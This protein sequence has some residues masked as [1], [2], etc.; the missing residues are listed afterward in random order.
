MTDQPLKIWLDRNG[1][2]LRLRLSRPKANIVDAE[3]IGAL[4]AAI[5]DYAGNDDILAILIDHL[6]R[7]FQD[8]SPFLARGPGTMDG[9]LAAQA[10]AG[11]NRVGKIQL[12]VKPA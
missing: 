4:D 3:M 7:A 5:S 12:P 11:A 2:L 6:G 8:T 10:I 9:H 1:R